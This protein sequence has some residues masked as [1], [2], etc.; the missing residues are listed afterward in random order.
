MVTSIDKHSN[1]EIKY[2]NLR[3]AVK[4]TGLGIKK[5][6]LQFLF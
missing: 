2:T 1:K 5:D 6:D 3:I 4:D